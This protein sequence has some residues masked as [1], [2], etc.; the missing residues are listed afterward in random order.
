LETTVKAELLTFVLPTE[1]CLKFH[2]G[3]FSKISATKGIRK[4]PKPPKIFVDAGVKGYLLKVKLAHSLHYFECLAKDT[5]SELAG[6]KPTDYTTPLMLNVGS[7]EYS[8]IFSKF[9]GLN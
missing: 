8:S 5:K 6:L 3:H 1:K 9:F 4:K 7:C 2:F